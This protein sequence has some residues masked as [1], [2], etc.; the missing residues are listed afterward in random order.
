MTLPN[1][2]EEALAIHGAVEF[3]RSKIGEAPRVALVLGSGLGVL[4]E[5]I[6]NAAIIPYSEIPGFPISTAPGHVGRLVAGRLAGTRVLVMQGRFHHYEGYPLTRIAFPVRVFKALGV[7]TLILTNAA[8][9]V[10]ESFVPGDFM[11][12]SDHINLNGDNPCIG[13][14][15]ENLGPRFF[16]MSNTYDRDLRSIAHSIGSSLGI[17]LR[18]GVYMWFTGP[19][20]ETPAE[21]RAARILGADAVGMSTVPEAIAA[22]HCGLKVLGISCLT[23]MAAGIT[24]GRI[25]SEEVLEIS[26]REKPR[27]S[28]LVREILVSIESHR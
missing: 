10:N 16:D 23:N 17:N 8:G 6:E 7:E 24:S 25:T 15:N 11:L 28:S 26:E 14:N 13:P 12:I 20:F 27:F 3:I 18:D 19:S 4:A 9:A 1:I 22:A 2:T 21:I 5:E